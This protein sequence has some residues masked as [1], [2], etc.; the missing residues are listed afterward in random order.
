M[1]VP[2]A[3]LAVVGAAVSLW[4]PAQSAGAPAATADARA[5]AS[6]GALRG[7]LGRTMAGA[8]PASGAH[9][10]DATDGRA[11]FSWRPDTARILASNVK[12]FTTSA[13][14][15]RYGPDARIATTVL[16]SGTLTEDGTWRGNLYL[17]GGGDPSF[18]GAA[19]ARREYA[20]AATVEQLAAQIEKNGI[21]RVSGGVYGDESLFDSL[22]GGPD[23]GFG[24]S[25]WVGP[26]SALSYDRGLANSRGTAFQARPPAFA[27]L[28]LD[29]ALER[30]GVRVS[31]PPSSAVTPAT[32]TPLAEVRSPALARLIQI[33]NK[34]SDNFFAEMLV[35][36]L[37]V[38]DAGGGSLRD[39]DDPL[40]PPPVA[41]EDGSRQPRPA[42]RGTTLGG[43]RTAAAFAARLGGGPS[44]LVDGSG[45]SRANRAS[46]RRVAAL[47]TRMRR[48]SDFSRFYDSLAIAG[49]DGTL[50][51]RMR[52][53]AARGR[54]R[55]KTGT[56]SNVSALSGYCRARNGHTIVF[57]ILMN[58]VS[59]VGARRLQDRMAQ[60]MAAFSG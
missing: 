34:R 10:L 26:L 57:S 7:A 23:S 2:K 37:G 50:H 15:G 32:A 49:R 18:G 21:R 19:F 48:R 39:A 52:G 1:R 12:L 35:K 30:A 8:G 28:R 58:N 40:P 4:A 29:A 45:L 56:L 55:A 5:A 31:R 25:V 51:D 43:A 59:P 44:R 17:R 11:L 41:G 47:L 14:L 60:A 24:T 54:C 33:T 6:A 46:P 16:G 53:G 3:S 22:R 38:V 42:G 20:S 36:G 27:A 13:A 9:V